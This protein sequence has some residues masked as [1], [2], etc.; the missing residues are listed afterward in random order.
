MQALKLQLNIR[1]Q[2]V[3]L[4]IKLIETNHDPTWLPYFLELRTGGQL[5]GG[6]AGSLNDWGP[7]Y[8][9]PEEEVWFNKIYEVTRYLFDQD[10]EPSQADNFHSIKFRN[11][12]RIIRCLNCNKSYQHPSV[13][14]THFALDFLKNSFV[15]FAESNKLIEILDPKQTFNSNRV[16]EYRDWLRNEYSNNN[17]KVYD[18][19][20]ANY[21]CP[22]C[23]KDHAETE[24]DLYKIDK[25]ILDD[26]IFKL[27]KQNATW[28]D[29]EE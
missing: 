2:Y 16:I 15:V 24:H 11:N 9:N 8:A 5:P 1:H 20:S 10:L 28:S 26:R 19:V 14:E 27:S 4:L 25:T 29:F 22:N 7:S 21:V 18:F 12:I 6:G 13:F 17:I 3:E 23:R